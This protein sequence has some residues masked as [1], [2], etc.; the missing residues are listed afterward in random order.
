MPTKSLEEEIDDVLEEGAQK[1]ASA[2]AA[3]DRRLHQEWMASGK[4]PEKLQPLLR[5]YEPFIANKTRQLS[6]AQQVHP[7]ATRMHVTSAVVQAF[8]T[9]DP[10]RGTALNTHVQNRSQGALRS[11][12]KAQN[13]ARIPE[14]DALQIGKY[15]RAKAKLEDELGA[16]P[17]HSQI[18]TEMGISVNRLKR[19]EQR[20]IRD[21]SSGGFEVPVTQSTSPRDRE[22]LPLI[23]EQLN[24]RDQQ[25]FD[26]FY[27]NN[28][29]GN[30]RPGQVAKKLNMPGYE[31][32][33][34]ISR[35]NQ[36]FEEYK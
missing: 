31:V 15:D 9:Y 23:R 16:K 2:R 4:D 21:L 24:P 5:R 33:R 13:I 34:S 1:S 14:D 27:R 28:S 29:S 12:I 26:E 7:E 35:I 10:N 17:T 36:K 3:E 20:R 30:V 6:G 25:V 8:E 22:I 19:I 18:A 11:V 32:S